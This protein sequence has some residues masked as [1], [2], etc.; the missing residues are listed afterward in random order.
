[1]PDLVLASAR[2]DVIG[3]ELDLTALDTGCD[4]F[5]LSCGCNS[6]G[7]YRVAHGTGLI[8]E[9]TQF[10]YRTLVARLIHAK[11]GAGAGAGAQAVAGARAGAC[12]GRR[13]GIG[14]GSGPGVGRARDTGKGHRC[15][16]AG[17]RLT[18]GGGCL[19]RRWRLRS[20]SYL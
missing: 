5:P 18:G 11:C 9:E 7:Y 10:P 8:P 3:R 19:S 2:P 4:L 12:T 13:R 6:G 14:R 17:L 15:G 20:S 1:M 16:R